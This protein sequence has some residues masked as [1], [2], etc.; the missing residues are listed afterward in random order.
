MVTV[1]IDVLIYV[2]MEVIMIYILNTDGT[3]FYMKVVIYFLH[4]RD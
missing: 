2:Y 1:I 3:N 4:R